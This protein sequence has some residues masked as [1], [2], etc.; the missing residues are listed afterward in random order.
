M[1]TAAFAEDDEEEEIVKL[2]SAH[3]ELIEQFYL[4]VAGFEVVE[5]VEETE[6]KAVKGGM[7]FAFVK[8]LREF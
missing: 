7:G 2:R 6:D 1:A 3:Q 8:Q 5:G 4:V